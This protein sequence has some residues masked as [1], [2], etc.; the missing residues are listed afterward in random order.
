MI[1]EGGEGEK[2]KAE[3]ATK[4]RRQAQRIANCERSAEGTV[5][6]SGGQ[7]R[8]PFFFAPT[9][10]SVV[11]VAR[12]CCRGNNA[13]GPTWSTCPLRHRRGTPSHCTAEAWTHGVSNAR[14]TLMPDAV[15]AVGCARVC[16]SF[17]L[18]CL[19][20]PLVRPLRRRAADEICPF[21]ASQTAK[22]T[23]TNHTH[24]HSREDRIRFSFMVVRRTQS[25]SSRRTS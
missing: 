23:R 18:L 22:H 24:A 21:S 10:S 5:G 14:T 7:P 8:S 15:H 17:A 12:L 9:L 4:A 19:L 3:T 2:Q 20:W 11:S 6:P 13:A 16:S 1:A 25:K